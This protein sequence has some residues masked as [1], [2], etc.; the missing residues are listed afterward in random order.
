MRAGHVSPW[1]E[2]LAADRA[3]RHWPT[4][5]DTDLNMF[6]LTPFDRD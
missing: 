3:K 6:N 4:M 1:H 5:P 2:Q